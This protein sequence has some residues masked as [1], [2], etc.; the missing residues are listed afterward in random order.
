VTVPGHEE[1]NALYDLAIVEPD[2]QTRKELV[3][4]MQEIVTLDMIQLD[5]MWLDNLY[6]WRDSVEGYGDGV[7]PAGDIDLRYITAFTE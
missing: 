7:T 5:M 6:A 1:Y 2:E 3:W 4:Q